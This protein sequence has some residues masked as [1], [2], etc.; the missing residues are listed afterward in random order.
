MSQKNNTQKLLAWAQQCVRDY[1]NAK[2]SS[3]KKESWRDGLAFLSILH[4]Y[5]PAVLPSIQ[6]ITAA[7]SLENL[8]L[9]FELG[10]KHFDIE[11]YLEPEGIFLVVILLT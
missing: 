8:K 2:I 11:A 7:T 10:T 1:P 6:Q 9:A 5:D 3:F 4:Y